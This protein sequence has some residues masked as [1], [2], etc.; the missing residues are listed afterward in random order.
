[1][2]LAGLAAALLAG[3]AL[4]AT[5]PISLSPV[6]YLAPK[7]GVGLNPKLV[8]VED[9]NRDGLPDLAT[10]NSDAKAVSVLLGT[11]GGDFL[12]ATNFAVGTWPHVLA[13]GDFNEDQHPDLVTAATS[14]LLGD[15]QGAF[16]LAATYRA[17]GAAF[18]D[19][20]VAEVNGDRHLDFVVA[21]TA[22]S[23]VVAF[24]G[25]GTGAFPAEATFPAGSGVTA[26]AVADFNGDGHA[27]L[28]TGSQDGNGAI[29]FLAGDGHGGFGPP[30]TV[31]RVSPGRVQNLATGDLDRD[32]KQDLV[33]AASNQGVT[34]LRGDGNG[35]FGLLTTLR[36]N[37]GVRGA[38]L[39]DLNGDGL[40]DLVATS[41]DVFVYTGLGDGTFGDL[42]PFRVTTADGQ[43]ARP[44]VA[45]LD[46]DGR[47]DLVVGNILGHLISLFL[48]ETAPV[49]DIAPV[50]DGVRL[51]WPGWAYD[52][53]ST[54]DLQ[55]PP[56]WQPQPEPSWL[57]D[58]R[59]VVT[60]RVEFP[61][62][63]Y[64]LKQR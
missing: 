62:R 59:R 24:Y 6:R 31:P 43:V 60:N 15:G 27:D 13:A 23:A 35:S 51:S 47:P 16:R 25:D 3:V 55:S 36:R 34:V 4:G 17:D 42:K 64:R 29:R 14:V 22:G 40:L 56:N 33:A 50:A 41:G 8:V 48:N 18:G 38:A 10:G 61:A 21:D 30:T 1:M 45:D 57:T 2:R 20:A 37:L 52:L 28:V 32:G 54:S 11:A 49:L 44:T 53:E 26:L 9:F 5:P 58:N 63:F 39:G 12:P 19:V 7:Y 46:R